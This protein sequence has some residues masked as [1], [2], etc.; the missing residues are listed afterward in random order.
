MSDQQAVRVEPARDARRG[1]LVV[2]LITEE[3]L[4]AMNISAADFPRGQG[5]LT[6]AGLPIA[7]S[8]RIKVPRAAEAQANLE[9]VLH[10]HQLP[11][12]YTQF[13]G[14]VVMLH[15]A[16]HLKRSRLHINSFAPTGHHG[17]SSF[18]GR[19]TDRFDLTRPTCTQWRTSRN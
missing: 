14:R 12:H 6:A 2:N 8:S 15:V 9:C 1:E 5:E 10:S 17:S 13:I 4:T 16:D 19:T 18:Y 7:A 11:G 3:L